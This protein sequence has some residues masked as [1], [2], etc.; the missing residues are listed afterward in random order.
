MFFE[1][2]FK[3]I[4][5]L[6]LAPSPFSLSPHPFQP[7]SVVMA[8]L[9][10]N[11]SSSSDDDGRPKRTGN[12]SPHLLHLLFVTIHNSIHLFVS[13]W[14][15][16]YVLDSKCSYNHSRNWFGCVIVSMGDRSARMD[17]RSHRDAPICLHKLLYLLFA[18][19]LLSLQR[20][21]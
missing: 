10:I 3:E 5:L 15:F 19:W 6:P 7:Y 18:H 20:L 14:M 11:D 16:R 2:L 12:W 8:V 17:C 1:T 4:V 13:S 9:P 21:S